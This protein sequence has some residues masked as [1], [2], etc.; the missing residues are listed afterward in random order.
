MKNAD[1][2]S[3]DL[4]WVLFI[5]PNK[6]S[7]DIHAADLWT[8]LFLPYFLLLLIFKNSW[9][10]F[11]EVA[12]IVQSVPIYCSS[13]FPNVNILHHGVHLSKLRNGHWYNTS[14]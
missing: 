3:A 2:D 5:I 12:N 10:T 6:L 9:N 1:S 14:N 8:K 13:H 7:G 11:R 4:E